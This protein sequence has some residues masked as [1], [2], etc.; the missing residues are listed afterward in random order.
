MLLLASPL[1][2]GLVAPLSGHLS[3]RVGAKA[4]TVVGLAIMLASLGLMC[5]LG[6][7]SKPGFVMACLALFGLG[8]GVFGSP[9]TKL[10]M[11]HAPKDK[12]GIAGS[13][14]ALARNVGMVS[15]IAFSVALLDGSMSA[16]LGK[17][18]NGFVP[19]HPEVFVYGM[20]VVFLSAAALC[21]AA[22]GLTLA[23]ALARERE[24]PRERA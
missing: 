2:S 16:R 20:R 4:L 18:V 13:I 9:N 24:L 8:S 3:D 6:L 11:T 17:P 22:I 19:E 5:L 15:G 21:V 12:L 10:I 1:A 14:N 7:G 23:R